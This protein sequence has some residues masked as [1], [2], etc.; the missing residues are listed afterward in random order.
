MRTLL[1]SFLR[2]ALVVFVLF[3]IIGITSI[4]WFMFHP[5]MVRETYDAS[6]EGYVDV[7][8]NGETI[9]AVVLGPKHGKKAILR[10]HGNA[11]NMYESIGVLRELTRRGFTVAAV[12]YP[13]YGLSS[14][15]PTEEGCYRAVHRLYEWLVRERGFA[16]KDIIVD[17]FSIGTGPATELAATEPVGGLILEAP[18]LSAPRVVTKVRLL[19]IDPFPNAARLRK[20][21]RCPVLILH[22][23]NDR[24]VPFAQGAELRRLAQFASDEVRFIPV[25]GADHT[26]I[27]D[28]LGCDAYLDLLTGFVDEADEISARVPRE[29]RDEGVGVFGGYSAAVLVG[30]GFA[31]AGTLVVALLYNRRR[32]MQREAL[33]QVKLSRQTAEK[34][35]DVKFSTQEV[36]PQKI[37][38]PIHVDANTMPLGLNKLVK[39][40]SP[41]DKGVMG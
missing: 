21:V 39:T 14:G 35:K 3:E 33:E 32:R 26:E 10:C 15:R 12:D 6:A 7:G 17:G 16:P 9:A 4:D 34:L 1:V 13:G 36:S 22:G 31:F 23:T 30:G 20:G 40:G 8:T 29:V 24:V 28:V 5:E 25:A 11:E 19:P 27:A 41:Y 38:R 37:D 18:F 2:I